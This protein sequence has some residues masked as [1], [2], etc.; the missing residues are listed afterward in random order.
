MMMSTSSPGTVR[1]ISAMLASETGGRNIRSRGS[2]PV[3]PAILCTS[4]TRSA[5]GRR[6]PFAVG[7]ECRSG[8]VSSYKA[9]SSTPGGHDDHTQIDAHHHH[10]D[11]RYLVLA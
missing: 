10:G 6:E 1:P 5:L 11:P 7:Q 2:Q 4:A 3:V 8:K 9:G